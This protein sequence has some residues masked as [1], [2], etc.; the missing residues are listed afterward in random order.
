MESRTR[1]FPED[2]VRHYLT[3]H[4]QFQI[5]AR[6]HQAMERFRHHALECGALL[7]SELVRQ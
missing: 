4:I 5:G 1:G 3:H 2:L 7:P 6:E